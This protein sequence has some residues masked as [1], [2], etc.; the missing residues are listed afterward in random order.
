MFNKDQTIKYELAKEN[1]RGCH[2]MFRHGDIDED[3]QLADSGV[4]IIVQDF[5]NYQ[6]FVLT[7]NTKD[8]LKR[9]Y[10]LKDNQAVDIHRLL[11]ARAKKEIRKAEDLKAES[12]RAIP[13]SR[14]N[15][16]LGA[17]ASVTL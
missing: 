8:W 4:R 6:P 5:G 17:W 11:F 9:T 15:N 7:S 3:H 16:L 10:T 13:K 14:D 2:F 1:A 12:L